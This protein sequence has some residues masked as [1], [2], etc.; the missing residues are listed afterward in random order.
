MKNP[1]F[2]KFLK[3]TGGGSA[4]ARAIDVT[5]VKI[6]H[7]ANGN[8]GVSKD[9]AHRIITAFPQINLYGLLYPN[10]KAA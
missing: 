2:E 3:I 6:S 4:S 8:R 10:G 7:I 9:M 1:E 5:P